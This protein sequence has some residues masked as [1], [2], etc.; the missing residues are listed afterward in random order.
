MKAHEDE[1]TK[2]NRT[3]TQGRNSIQ[4][5]N[6]E[7]KVEYMKEG[8]ERLAALVKGQM[9]KNQK[10]ALVGHPK[11]NSTQGAIKF[12]KN[13]PKGKKLLKGMSLAFRHFMKQ[14]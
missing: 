1:I 13:D 4:K 2:D 11:F 12:Y 7:K 5:T 8:K 14:Q 6:K 10:K 9:I 3:K